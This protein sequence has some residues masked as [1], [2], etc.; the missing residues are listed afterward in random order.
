MRELTKY[1]AGIKLMIYL[2]PY[3]NERDML[4]SVCRSAP[5]MA[6]RASIPNTLIKK[7]KEG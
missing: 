5:D 1:G 6:L 3:L 2:G 4:H 7:E